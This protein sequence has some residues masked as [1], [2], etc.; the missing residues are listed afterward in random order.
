MLA[1][2]L[3]APGHARAA[4]GERSP[5]GGG[6][7]A[8]PFSSLYERIQ[9]RERGHERLLRPNRGC[10]LVRYRIHNDVEQL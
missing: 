8:F 5:A 3:P 1:H 7:F 6:V 9:Q 2:E 4:I 10:P